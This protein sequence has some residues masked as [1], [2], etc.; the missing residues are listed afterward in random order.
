[1]RWTKELIP[2]NNELM[3]YMLSRN[4]CVEQEPM[5]ECQETMN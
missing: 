5:K 1:M 2:R 3:N 4:E